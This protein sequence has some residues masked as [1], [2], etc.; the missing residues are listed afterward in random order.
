MKKGKRILALMAVILM[1]G[2]CIASLVLAIIGTPEALN[3][4]RLTF[5]LAIILPVLMYGYILTARFLTGAGKNDLP[6][7]DPGSD[8]DRS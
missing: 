1:A 3:L 6:E 2:L 4:F 5:G 8:P 7:E